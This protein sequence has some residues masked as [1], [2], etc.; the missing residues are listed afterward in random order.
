M[1][2]IKEILKNEKYYSIIIILIASIFI[3]IP[4][5]SKNIDMTYD[6]G[7]Q[8]IARI[9]G[10][11]QSLQ[12]GETAIM[13]N[14][15][16]GFGYSW[17][18]FYSPLTAFAPLIFKTFGASFTVCI[19]CFMFL[20]VFLSGYFMYLFT[21]KITKNSSIAII[22]SILYIFA[23]YRLTD[24]YIRNALAELTSF[25]FLPLIF[26]G[27]YNIFN[28]QKDEK[29]EDK[30]II[31]LKE[32]YY[33]KDS[34]ILTLGTVGLILTHTIVTMYT[35]IFAIIYVIINYKK[36]KDKKVL[37]V[38]LIN[39]ILILVIT[40][41]FWVPLLQHKTQADYEVFK[42][43]RMERTEVLVAYKL[44]FY[45]LFF[46]KS[47]DYMIYDIGIITLLGL[48]FTPSAIKKI[49][50]KS[51]Y[52]IYKFALISGIISCIMTLKIFPFEYLP[53]I[54]KM[55]QF[56]FRLLEFS[57]FFFALVSAINIA[58]LSKKVELKELIIL[59]SS[60]MVLTVPYTT[61]LRTIDYIDEQRLINTV[62]VTE[63]TGRVHAG[64][65][66]F[67]YLPCKA[68]ENRSYIEKRSQDAI[69]L[70]GNAQI[71]NAN[72]NG[73]KMTFDVNYVLE[74]TKIELPYIYYLGYDVTLEQDGK[75]EKLKTYETENGFVGITVPITEKAKIKVKY[76]GTFAM[77]ISGFISVIGICAFIGILFLG[78]EEKNKILTNRQ[79]KKPV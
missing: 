19:K 22:A 17:N 27:L 38:L 14:F 57:S 78:S 32:K 31:Q 29:K 63:N 2:K 23:P 34:L 56:S 7:I 71:E 18:L 48:V 68:F 11:Y 37:K 50:N 41:F 62:P 70:S 15:C 35:T 3:C 33:I 58:T 39:I 9:I 30:K 65:A 25:V 42:E 76:E 26:L 16:N 4:L 72:K 43:G 8:H 49:K 46:T 52:K 45:R 13:S 53:R 74:E 28:E 67:E 47:N 79:Y 55:I 69:I 73:S 36:L 40:A 51:Y 20:V 54:L 6:D 1:S 21:K 61:H 59:L 75:K 24:M 60:I 12:E 64:C 66:S 44:D 77:K 5:I 10:T